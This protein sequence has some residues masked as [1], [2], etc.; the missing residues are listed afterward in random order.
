MQSL[1]LEGELLINQKI[2]NFNFVVAAVKL[3]AHWQ[4]NTSQRNL[5]KPKA[6]R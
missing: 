2:I 6:F 3:K 5:K 1:Q 4:N